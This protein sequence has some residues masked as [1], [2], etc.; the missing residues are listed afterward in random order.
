MQNE[1]TEIPQEEQSTSK[2]M[3]F[4]PKKKQQEEKLNRKERRRRQAIQRKI[5]KIIAK[6]AKANGK[7]VRRSQQESTVA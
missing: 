4:V 5:K 1:R 3:K 6:K 2:P 7:Q